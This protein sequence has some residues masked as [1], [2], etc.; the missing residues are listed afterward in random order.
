MKILLIVFIFF[1]F[2]NITLGQQTVRERLRAASKAEIEIRREYYNDGSLRSFGKYVN[3]KRHG[4]FSLFYS[5]GN[6]AA[7]RDYREGRLVDLNGKPI[8][9]VDKY[10]HENGNIWMEETYEDGVKNGI[11]KSYHEDGFLVSEMNYINGKLEGSSKVYYPDGILQQIKEYKDGLQY[12]L[13]ENYHQN[14]ELQLKVS[15]RNDKKNGPVKKYYENGQV[16]AEG[17]YVNGFLEGVSKTYYEN[18]ILW[19]HG[20]RAKG[21]LIKYKEYD[22]DGKL[23]STEINASELYQK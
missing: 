7:I 23:V 5:N 13:M 21:M 19:K 15:F 16:E 10:Y 18:G 8:N 4:T 6:V 9:D 22:R 14:S 11:S 17:E 3:G 12:G 20:V 1:C 2:P